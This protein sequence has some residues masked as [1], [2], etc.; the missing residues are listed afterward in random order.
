MIFSSVQQLAHESVDVPE[1]LKPMYIRNVR[2]R[3]GNGNV[4]RCKSPAANKKNEEETFGVFT[5]VG[6]MFMNGP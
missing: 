1:S 5:E 6:S 4:T 3:I 2:G